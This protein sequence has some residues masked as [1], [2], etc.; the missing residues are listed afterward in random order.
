[1]RRVQSA[2]LAIIALIVGFALATL[3]HPQSTFAISPARSPLHRVVILI[4]SDNEK[5]MGHAISYSM[6]ITRAYA[7]KNEKVS[8]EIVANGSGIRLFRSDTS[9]LQ[10]PLAYLRQNIPGIVFSMCDSSRQIA[11]E[12][13]GHAIA[14]IPGARLVPFGVG[15]V[16]ELEEAG[17]SY[18]HG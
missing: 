18:I 6:N 3:L 15:R 16:V 2:F 12:K 1:M 13:E 9:P 14:L 8:I 10:Q 5:I 11:E 17:W 7:M 4:D